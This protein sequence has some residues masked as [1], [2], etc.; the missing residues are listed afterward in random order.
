MA[1]TG[2]DGTYT[3]KNVPPGTYKLVMKH[4]KLGEQTASVT[5]ETGKTVSQD[6]TLK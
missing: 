4:E 1:I 6:F 3:I 2:E 5:V